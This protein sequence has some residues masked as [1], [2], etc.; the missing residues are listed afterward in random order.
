M[1]TG[2]LRINTYLVMA[3]TCLLVWGCQSPETKRKKQLASFRVHMEVNPN[4]GVQSKSVPIYRENPVPINV[5]K[6]YFLSEGDVSETK[7]MDT[8]GGIE[9][10]VQLTRQGRWLL[11]QYSSA[12]I[13]KHMA[14]F[15]QF[16]EK[17]RKNRWLAAP[18]ITHRITDGLLIFTPDATREEADEIALGLNNV[19]K[20]VQEK[21]PGW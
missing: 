8:V 20:Q 9:L 19:A 16:G 11:E 10:S 21:A 2:S 6:A 1:S 18:K 4:A 17:L 5:D 14:I 12:N 13:G 7:V 15:A 3:L